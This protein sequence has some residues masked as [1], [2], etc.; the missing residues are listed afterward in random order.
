MIASLFETTSSITDWAFLLFF[1]VS[2]VVFSKIEIRLL[3]SKRE[4][5]KIFWRVS[6]RGLFSLSAVSM[7]GARLCA[8]SASFTTGL[9]SGFIFVVIF[10]RKFEVR[11]GHFL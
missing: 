1:M 3:F 7:A 2:I 10:L 8:S 9:D 4:S 11:F 5:L 6:L